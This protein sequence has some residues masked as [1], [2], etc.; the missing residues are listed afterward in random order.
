MKTQPASPILA[1]FAALLLFAAGCNAPAK[2]KHA[3][4]EELSQVNRDF[5]KA[6]NAKD[7][8]A[9]A[10]CYADD[11]VILP[12]GQ[13]TV[14]GHEAIQKYWQ[15]FLDGA[16]YVDGTVSTIATGSNGDLGY[17][18]GTA[19]LHLKGPDG[20]IMTEK[21]KYTIVLKRNAEG[22]WLQTYDMWNPVAEPTA[23]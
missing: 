6:L 7:A 3:T 21:I 16:G 15:G 11:A 18:I 10:N 5:V 17:E 2:E 20:K 14:T 8:T 9:A 1:I 13:P 22:K 4:V 23:K 19:D 12:P